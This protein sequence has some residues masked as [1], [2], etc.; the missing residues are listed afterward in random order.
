[1]K[2]LSRMKQEE[3][4]EGRCERVVKRHTENEKVIR[5]LNQV[6]GDNWR[7]GEEGRYLK[8]SR[9]YQIMMRHGISDLRSSNNYIQDK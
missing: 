7:N 5:V 9:L 3:Q 4:S 8:V 6:A 1:M 2:K